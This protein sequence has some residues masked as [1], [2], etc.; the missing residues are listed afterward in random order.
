MDP[1]AFC[2]DLKKPPE[3]PVAVFEAKKDIPTIN[4]V[5]LV[6]GT[7]K[8]SMLIRTLTTVMMELRNWGRD[9]LII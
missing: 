3:M 6:S 5:M 1:S 2:W 4:K 9:W 8:N 7:F